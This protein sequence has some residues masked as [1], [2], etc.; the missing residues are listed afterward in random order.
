VS[1]VVFLGCVR[2]EGT[3]V[4]EITFLD[5]NSLAA[6][7][8]SF[9]VVHGDLVKHDLDS[10]DQ[11]NVIVQGDLIILVGLGT[12]S[13]AG[14]SSAVAHVEVTA[15]SAD[16][17]H[18]HVA[19]I[20]IADVRGIQVIL[21]VVLHHHEVVGLVEKTIETRELHAVVASMHV[22]VGSS[23]VLAKVHAVRISTIDS[24]VACDAGSAAS[25]LLLILVSGLIFVFNK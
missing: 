7:W 5:V 12:S 21:H 14:V 15:V 8:A 1:K 24:A 25:G 11:A 10:F 22:V 17:I 20:L 2:K 23:I 3:D 6:E 18:T 13:G 16:I 4:L 9:V 19:A